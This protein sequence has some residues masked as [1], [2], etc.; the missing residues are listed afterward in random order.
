MS[1]RTMTR[2]ELEDAVSVANIATCQVVAT[3]QVV[4]EQMRSMSALG[5]GQFALV[6][7]TLHFEHEEA[8]SIERSTRSIHHF[9]ERLR[10]LVRKTDSTLLCGHTMYFLLMEATLEGAEIVQQRLWDALLWE[11]HSTNELEIVR[12]SA[13]LLGYSAYP[14]PCSSFEECQEAA[15]LPYRHFESRVQRERVAGKAASRRVQCSD[16]EVELPQLARQMGV[17]YLSLLPRTVPEQVQQLV[18]AQ[19]AHELHCYPLG[20]DKD[21]LTVALADPQNRSILARLEHETGLHIFPVLTHPGE[22]QTALDQ[23]H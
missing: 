6:T 14:A 5:V 22:L 17:P 21:V 20:R 2:A 15:R 3:D 12:P 4:I 23:L 10:A 8:R 1:S 18:N 16:S 7:I 11:I 9:F 19:L 13:M